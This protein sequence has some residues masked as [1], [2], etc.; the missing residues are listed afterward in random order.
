MEDKRERVIDKVVEK[1]RR[2]VNRV[3]RKID[4]K[5]NTRMRN[6]YR[7]KSVEELD[8]IKKEKLKNEVEGLIF[9][10]WVY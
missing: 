3:F 1:W 7:S 10:E 8:K 9:F 4:D 2:P 5:Y 6:K